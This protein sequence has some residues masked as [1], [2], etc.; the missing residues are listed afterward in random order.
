MKKTLLSIA[1]ATSISPAFS[2]TVLN[3]F[4]IQEGSVPGASNNL[5]DA[6]KLA[7]FYSEVF[8]VV[9]GGSGLEFSSNAYADF[10]AIVKNDG[11]SG[12]LNQLGNFFG[13]QYQMYA[14]FSAVGTVTNSGGNAQFT[15]TAGSFSLFIDSDSNTSKALGID[16]FAA[17]ILGGTSDDY[18][19]ASS[20]DLMSLANVIGNP[21]AFD[22]W[23]DNFL[24]TTG[25]Q[26]AGLIGNQNGESYFVN[27]RPF[28]LV[29][30]VDGDFDNISF[31][32]I[33][34]EIANTGKYTTDVTGEVSAV[35][36]IPEPASL[37]LLGIG[38]LGLGFN[39]R[40][41]A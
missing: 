19:I 16:G 23:F 10:S 28:Y 12:T 33:A 4:Q 29:T 40:K 5:I 27:P 36:N 22:L 11:G 15:G 39:R 41:Q 31:A 25:D 9:A 20:S 2:A 30:N 13:Q 32:D 14:L 26:N 3:D 6:D 38:M 37:A 17:P 24:L 35:F 18:L 8:S 21:G 7:G 1:L 34:T